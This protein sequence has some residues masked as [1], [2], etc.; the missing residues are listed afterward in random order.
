MAAHCKM[1]NITLDYNP[2]FNVDYA[3]A[4]NDMEELSASNQF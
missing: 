1:L 2:I 3:V 4:M